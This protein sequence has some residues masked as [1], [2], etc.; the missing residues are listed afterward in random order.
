MNNFLTLEGI[1]KSFGGVHALKGIDANLVS[2]EI[3]HLLGENGCGKSTL[4]KIISGA[5][6]PDKG[7]LTFNGEA[8]QGLTPLQALS[9]GIETVYQDLSLLPNFTVAENVALT[10]QLVKSNGQLAR[11]IDRSA[12]YEVA[13]SA[14][15]KIGIAADQKFLDREVDGLPI[16]LRQMIA[17]AR[18]VATQAK[19]VIMDEPTT[20][21][22][23]REIDRLI[24][25]VKTLQQDG[26]TVLFVSHKLDECKEIGG[27]VL[28]FRD[29]RKINE[30]PIDKFSTAQISEQMTGKKLT[31]KSYRQ[32]AASKDVLLSVKDLNI[33][34]KLFD[35]SLTLHKGEVLGVIG[36]LGSG[37]TELAKSLAG[38]L[39]ADSGVISIE[40]KTLSLDSPRAAIG[41]SIGYVPEDRLKEGLFLD[42]TIADNLIVAILDRFKSKFGMLSRKA[43]ESKAA[44]QR[45]E[46]QLAA[47]DLNL[48][49]QSL[50]GGNQQRVVVGRWLAISPKVLILHA[51]TM[52]VDVGSKDA[53]YQIVQ[54]QVSN[55]CG[56]LLVSD[57]LP[58]LMQNCDRILVLANGRIQS[59]LVASKTS[60]AELSNILLGKAAA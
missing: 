15:A 19:L 6:L 20:A 33:A 34:E 40:G 32:Q 17:I 39:P 23:Q 2:G 37:R 3:Y 25:V 42:K 49:V 18:A 53:L 56:V 58:E 5:Q 9:R 16:A 41:A 26:V 24:G 48:P 46:L 7:T 44:D 54:Q 52:G 1:T 60:E 8:L 51:P 45:T 11:L 55:G 13:T 21:L 4:I 38:I 31:T 35:V 36:L 10:A 28:I 57:D 43:I 50:S 30:G 29:G 12:L 27:N 47:K 22:T 59:E 14:L